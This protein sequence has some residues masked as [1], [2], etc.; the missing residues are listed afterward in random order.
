MC[1]LQGGIKMQPLIEIQTV[2]ISIEFKTTSGKLQPESSTAELEMKTDRGGLQIKSSPIQLNVDSYEARNSVT[3]TPKT[4][5]EQFASDGKQAAFEATARYAQEGNILLDIHLNQDAFQRI[6]DLRLGNNVH[7]TPNI[8]WIPDQPVDISWE[9]GD[10]TIKYETDKL[11]FDFKQ[12]TTP[13]E[14][15]PG[16]IEVIIN[17]YPEVIITYVGGPLYVPPSADPDYIDTEA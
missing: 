3:P 12:N 9:P 11:N 2:P 17:Q 6:A 7:K 15:V 14:F 16:D 10:M 5:L 4:S 8:K 13:M 1:V